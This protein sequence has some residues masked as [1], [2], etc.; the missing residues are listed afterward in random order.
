MKTVYQQL[1]EVY[2]KKYSLNEE[3]IKDI[4]ILSNEFYPKDEI[5]KNFGRDSGLIIKSG[6]TKQGNFGETYVV[7]FDIDKFKSFLQQKYDGKNYYVKVRGNDLFLAGPPKGNKQLEINRDDIPEDVETELLKF[8][9]KGLDDDL[10]TIRI[11]IADPLDNFDLPEKWELPSAIQA[12][13]GDPKP[14]QAYFKKVYKALMD[15]GKKV[16]PGLKKHTEEDGAI[17]FKLSK[18]PDANMKAKLQKAFKGAKEI[19]V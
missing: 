13:V 15:A 18:E 9:W 2:T 7:D 19:E 11:Q 16:D 3:V 8:K 5:E 4:T 10:H 6:P 1:Q 17:V 12:Q 14:T